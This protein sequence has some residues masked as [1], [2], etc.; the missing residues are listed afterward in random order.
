LIK[1]H[2]IEFTQLAMTRAEGSQHM[3]NRVMTRDNI[4]LCAILKSKAT[5]YNRD[6]DQRALFTRAPAH[7]EHHAA[8]PLPPGEN[9]SD[10]PIVICNAH[11]HWDPEFC[12]VKLVQTMMLVNEL[13]RLLEEIAK[14]YRYN[15][16]LQIPLLICGDLN[17]LPKS[18]A[19]GIRV[20]NTVLCS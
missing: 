6:R 5:L 10:N 16:P 1:E 15:S 13:W 11:I 14:K 20:G 17:S 9:I 7:Y 3:L 4:G 2:L 18:G 12:D 8:L 19:Y